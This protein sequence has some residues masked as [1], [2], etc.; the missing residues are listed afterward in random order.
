VMMLAAAQGSVVVVEAEG[1]DEDKA[2]AA[3]VELIGSGF[4]EEVA[5]PADKGSR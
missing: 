1:G 3:L 2:I 4:G 5:G